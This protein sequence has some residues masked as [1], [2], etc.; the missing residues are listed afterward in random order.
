MILS[1]T[2]DRYTKI[3]LGLGNNWNGVGNSCVAVKIERHCVNSDNNDVR[4]NWVWDVIDVTCE[5]IQLM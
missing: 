5:Y 1:D 2:I 3:V 4:N